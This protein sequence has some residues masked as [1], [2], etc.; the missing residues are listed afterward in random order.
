MF[1]ENS[2]L[3]SGCT[4]V[5][6]KNVTL[7]KDVES[8]NT[9]IKLL[10]ETKMNNNTSLF[11][12]SSNKNRKIKNKN[13]NIYISNSSKDLLPPIT[14]SNT[15]LNKNKEGTLGSEISSNIIDDNGDELNL[16]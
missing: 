8:L 11:I 16:K 13:P 7:M 4:N 12:P 6:K 5:N 2:S 15:S 10:E 9:E 14:N 3:L 1:V